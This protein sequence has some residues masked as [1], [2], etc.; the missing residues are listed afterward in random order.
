MISPDGREVLIFTTIT[1]AQDDAED[2]VRKLRKSLRVFADED[3]ED[4]TV[5]FA[6][7]REY[8]K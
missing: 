4:D 2:A 3:S 8:P 6:W 1:F 5:R 7:T